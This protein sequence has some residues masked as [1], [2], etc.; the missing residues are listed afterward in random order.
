[1]R[2][3][4]T[5]ALVDGFYII[6]ENR[7]KLKVF[8][9]GNNSLL[10]TSCSSLCSLFLF[11]TESLYFV[12]SITTAEDFCNEKITHNCITTYIYC[13]FYLF[14]HSTSYCW[15]LLCSLWL[16]RNKMSWHS[17]CLW[18]TRSCKDISYIYFVFCH[19]T[20]YHM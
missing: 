20:V 14:T 13:C 19:F 3:N 18:G 5:N 2:L 8:L 11:R 1:M 16:V 9:I 6:L 10:N 12:L 15:A 4:M 17:F 7:E